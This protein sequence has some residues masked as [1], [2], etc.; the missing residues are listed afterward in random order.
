MSKLDGLDVITTYRKG[1]T[2]AIIRLSGDL[3]KERIPHPQSQHM[4]TP[5]VTGGVSSNP[6][7]HVYYTDMPR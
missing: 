5:D 1:V 2:S 3:I 7:E 4:Q 6:L